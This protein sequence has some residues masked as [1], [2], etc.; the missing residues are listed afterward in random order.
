MTP[1]PGWW[2]ATALLCMS[3]AAGPAAAQTRPA[4]REEQPA[5]A[6]RE[7]Q[8]DDLP[9]SLDR[10][11]EGLSHPSVLRLDDGRARFYVD[12]YGQLPKI[13]TFFEGFDFTPGPVPTT[14]QVHSDFL[15]MV[16]PRDLHSS[17]VTPAL[18]QLQSALLQ[19]LF[20]A[21]V[22][23]ASEARADYEIRRIRE[24]IRRELDELERRRRAAGY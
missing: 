15:A 17:A 16:T 22:G 13:E 1:T 24:Q 6:A 19:W 14:P 20:K 18:D 10:I 3:L 23:H 5:A 7:G 2:L 12:V 11:R 4:D 8:P 21:A 9:V